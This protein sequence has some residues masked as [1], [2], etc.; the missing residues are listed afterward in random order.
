MKVKKL[1]NH[2]IYLNILILQK[3]IEMKKILIAL[4]LTQSLTLLAQSLK[5]TSYLDANEVSAVINSTGELFNRTDITVA[6]YE[7]PKGEGSHPIFYGSFY[8]CGKDENGNLR[9][10]LLSFGE[11]YFIPGPYSTLPNFKNNYEYGDFWDKQIWKVS[12]AQ[13]A[14]H[15]ANYNNPNYVIP[16][17]IMT[18]PG[19]GRVDLGTSPNIAPF[20]DLN[21]DNIYSPENGDY[22]LIKGD[23]AVFIV[24]NDQ[25]YTPL[26]D[27]GIGV[28]LQAM[29][30]QFKDTESY[31]DSTTFI[32][33]KLIN[34]GGHS[35]DSLYTNFFL[36]ADLGNYSDD[37]SGTD[38]KRQML[39]FYNGDNDDE[40]N[41]QN[42]GYGLNPPA[43]GLKLLSS[44]IHSS[45][46]FTSN[47]SNYPYGDPGS[48]YDVNTP[49][50]IQ[51]YNVSKGKWANGENKYF[52]G[53]A[54]GDSTNTSTVPSMFMYTGESDL[55]GTLST[56]GVNMSAQ[57]PNGWSEVS[58]SNTPGDRRGTL[59]NKPFSFQDGDIHT[60][61]YSVL[62]A[63]SSEG[64]PFS[65]VNRLGEI[66]DSCQT[67]YDNSPEL[68]N[69]GNLTVDNTSYANYDTNLPVVGLNYYIG[70][71]L[72]RIEGYGN[73]NNRLELT[74]NSIDSIVQNGF[75]T[76]VEYKNG[77]GPVHIEVIDTTVYSDGA[78]TFEFYDLNPATNN[79]IDSAKWRIIKT[80][81]SEVL[82]FNGEFDI[83]VDTFQII[84]E[85]GLKVQVHQNKYNGYAGI[86]NTPASNLINSEL[87]FSGS[88]KWLTGV[89]DNDA[90][91]PTNWIAS[92]RD[93]D[94]STNGVENYLHGLSYKDEGDH[95]E[96]FENILEGIIAPYSLVR[97]TCDY[98]PL[99]YYNGPTS[100]NA[101]SY[102]TLSRIE[103][104]PNVNIVFTSDKSKWTRCP[105]IELGR[106]QT[107]NV[108]NAKP[109]GFRQSPSV[110]KNGNNDGTGIGMGWFPGYA[111]D[112]ETGVRLYLAFG[113]NSELDSYNGADM[114]W[115]PTSDLVDNNGK[116]IMGG[117][118]PI[119]IFNYDQKSINNNQYLTDFKAYIPTEAETDTS[120]YAYYLLNELTSNYSTSYKR[121]FYTSIAWVINPLLEP[122]HTLLENDAEIKVRINKEYKNYTKNKSGILSLSWEYEDYS[123]FAKIESL[124]K[125][126]NEIVK[127]FPNPTSG[128]LTIQTE[129]WKNKHFKVF[130]QV[131]IEVYSGELVDTKT[132][133]SL[134][135]LSKGLYILKLDNS[136]TTIFIKE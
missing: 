96:N 78:Y 132:E 59:T 107:N 29:I 32:S 93:S 10:S 20:V 101:G 100:D 37:F 95:D 38:V 92:G 66:A 50:Y 115:N 11:N 45:V 102:K 123:N 74:K 90:F 61:D 31:L 33:Y 81:D 46:N 52:G 111:I 108:G 133:I 128:K 88:A 99:T 75:V 48:Y 51:F 77:Y 53:N 109:G 15:R 118:H 69:F 76:D 129:N 34:K 56:G 73:G 80:T 79:S 87:N 104:L 117:Q 13:I 54:I 72:K 16:P 112:V 89:K 47:Q 4:I 2:L 105:V 41:G 17:E 5:K 113:E 8:L 98:A 65:S 127:L 22:P 23:E 122:G 21:G 58:N 71:K 19:N 43:I 36:D 94:T 27:A 130:D 135:H 62:Y 116:P 120:N 67:L 131:G 7:I 25:K 39:Y 82:T 63:R 42:L 3:N 9:M 60:I 86:F 121:Q 40:T 57:Y 49:Q 28:E 110:D 26:Y 114:I 64:L 1:K 30:Y 85:L 126:A 97:H 106:Y 119:Y 134:N 6:G 35:Y 14:I 83:S 12:K 91:F 125:S 44:E 70:P 103:Y 18:W 55:N 84:P 136:K 124:N 68:A 24:L